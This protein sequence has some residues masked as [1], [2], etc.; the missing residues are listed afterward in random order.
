MKST[1]NENTANRNSDTHGGATFLTSLGA[2]SPSKQNRNAKFGASSKDLTVGS[3]S[4]TKQ[5]SVV[6]KPP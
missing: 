1:L 3:L 2:G 6:A 5:S 4:P